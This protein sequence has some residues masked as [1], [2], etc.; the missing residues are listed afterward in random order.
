[1]SSED[2]GHSVPS[3]KDMP[4]RKFS[5]V[6]HAFSLVFFFLLRGCSKTV[7][8]WLSIGVDGNPAQARDLK[9]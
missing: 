2:R 9:I 4:E 3:A 1:M 7:L 5:V 8:Q 6:L